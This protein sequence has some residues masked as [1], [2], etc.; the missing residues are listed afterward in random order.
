MGC[1]GCL[2]TAAAAAGCAGCAVGN[3]NDVYAV[4]DID[5]NAGADDHNDKGEVEDR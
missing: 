2:G 4:G 1:L 5:V 3:V